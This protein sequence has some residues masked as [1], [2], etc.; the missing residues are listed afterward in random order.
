[1]SPHVRIRHK[2]IRQRTPNTPARDHGEEQTSR[3]RYFEADCLATDAVGDFV[4]I[5][6]AT[7][8]G[9]FQVAKVD[10]TDPSHFPTVGIVVEKTTTT[11]CFIVRFG[12]V[13]VSS[14]PSAPTL[15]PQT[16]YWIGSDSRLSAT[17]P[18]P[19]SGVIV[20]QTVGQALSSTEILILEGTQPYK[21]RA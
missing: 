1:M 21:L 8:G 15:T 17:M 7:V 20:S 19:T 10:I 2:D 5:S 11:R 18:S 4:Y 6:G 16:K 3:G 12:L 9:F 14:F 13:D